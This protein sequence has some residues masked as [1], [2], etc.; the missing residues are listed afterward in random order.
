MVSSIIQLT[1]APA[2]LDRL[3]AATLRILETVGVRFD[4]QEA[5]HIL[6]GGGVRVEGAVARITPRQVEWALSVTPRCYD[7]F[8]RH[9][10]LV[11]RRGASDQVWFGAGGG[12]TNT[13]DWRTGDVRPIRLADAVETAILTDRLPQILEVST[14]GF[15]SDVPGDRADLHA[16]VA[17]FANSIKPMVM[18]AG[19]RRSL[20]RMMDVISDDVGGLAE[21]QK[22]P[23]CEVG[24]NTVSP[25]VIEADGCDM[26]VDGARYGLPVSASGWPQLGATGPVTV[27]G[28]VVVAHA[29]CLAGLV[30]AQLVKEGTPYRVGGG[31]TPVF[32]MRSM[33]CSTGAPER[34]LG[35]ALL[36]QLGRHM[37]LPA[38]CSAV[39]TDA[40]GFGLQ[41][42]VERATLGLS[43]A[44]A[45]AERVGGLGWLDNCNTFSPEMLVLDCEMAEATRR[46]LAG[47]LV[48]EETL[49]LDVI[50]KVG[51]AGH[52]LETEHTLRHFRDAVWYP[53]LWGRSAQQPSAQDSEDE[54]LR[55]RT[56]ARIREL[57]ESHQPPP[58]SPNMQAA[59]QELVS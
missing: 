27:A 1:L 12:C 14:G 23:F 52:F 47:A 53:T 18:P 3:Q 29:E 30:L 31:S 6:R 55:A 16:F 56:R 19:N 13:L 32:D 25:L 43:A 36:L 2:V 38:M 51:P 58:I 26:L 41:A 35:N 33:V 9:G 10:H 54:A 49:A 57:L 22:R 40:K 5:R 59:L 8:D 45:G 46:F 24:V 39:G 15:I 37:G 34:A 21:V 20:R 28:S 17:R 7:L 50:E 44:L 48:D 11:V 42:G 4:G